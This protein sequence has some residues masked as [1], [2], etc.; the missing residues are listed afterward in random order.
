MWKRLSLWLRLLLLLLWLLLLTSALL[1]VLSTHQWPSWRRASWLLSQRGGQ[2]GGQKGVPRQRGARTAAV[3]QSA[4]QLK[5]PT[6]AAVHAH[7]PTWPWVALSSWW[8]AA[9]RGGWRAW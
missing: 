3:A 4:Q 9:G 2:R 5:G 6:T 1:R 7:L 8:L